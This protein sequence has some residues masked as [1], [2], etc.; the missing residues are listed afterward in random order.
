MSKHSATRNTRREFLQLVG[1]AG[2]VS[3]LTLTGRVSLAGSSGRVVVVGVGT[4]A[5]VMV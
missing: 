3:A 2:V 4:A 5:S 1:A